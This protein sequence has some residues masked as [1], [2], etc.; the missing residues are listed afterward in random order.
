MAP[1]FKTDYSQYVEV[2]SA[3]MNE[4]LSAL[5]LTNWPDPPKI[6]TSFMKN[7]EKR[8]IHTLQEIRSKNIT[9]GWVQ[10]LPIT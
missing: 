3:V 4:R 10:C 8:Q 5:K 1:I 2:V 9:P 7:K 6:L